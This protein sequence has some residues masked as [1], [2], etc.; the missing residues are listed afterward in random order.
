MSA[1]PGERPPEADRSTCTAC[2][3]T[4]EVV[5]NLGGS[6]SRVPCPWCEGS[7]TFIPGHDAQSPRS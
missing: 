4:G 7:G 1:G 6:P 5:S 2:R 3:G